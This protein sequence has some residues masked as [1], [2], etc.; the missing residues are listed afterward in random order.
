MRLYCKITTTSICIQ[1]NFQIS[2]E[3]TSNI[4]HKY[5]KETRSIQENYKPCNYEKTYMEGL[6]E[7]LDLIAGI[8]EKRNP[9][10][11]QMKPI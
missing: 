11:F 1:H 7:V 9:F 3:N 2:F 8:S 6:H 5:N 10:H 4:S